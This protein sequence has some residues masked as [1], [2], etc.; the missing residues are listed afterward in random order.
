MLRVICN[1]TE[2]EGHKSLIDVMNA[3]KKRGI[4]TSET[5]KNMKIS[6]CYLFLIA[7]FL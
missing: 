2:K 5:F 4:F 7:Y 6:L 1:Y 3:L